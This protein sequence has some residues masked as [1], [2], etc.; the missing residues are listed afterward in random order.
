MILGQR[1]PHLVKGRASAPY[2]IGMAIM[3]VWVGLILREAHHVS[4]RYPKSY[5]IWRWVE[6]WNLDDAAP[7]ICL[8]GAGIIVLALFIERAGY[9]IPWRLKSLGI[10]FGVVVFGF[11]AYGHLS[12]NF[13]S[14]AGPA[15]LFLAWRCLV[16]AQ[17]YAWKGRW[18]DVERE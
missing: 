3:L 14:V 15:Y 16:L 13:L 11:V 1:F 8:I 7:W 10:G 2:E 6:E 5:W 17:L 12:I 9:G 18:S 4:G